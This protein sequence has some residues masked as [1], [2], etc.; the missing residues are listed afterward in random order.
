[1]SHKARRRPSWKKNRDGWTLVLLN[2]EDDS[3][4]D[5]IFFKKG[6]IWIK[7]LVRKYGRD[8]VQHALQEVL[9][10]HARDIVE[11]NRKC[12]ERA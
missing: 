3:H 6:N 4:L 2:E 9:I 10:G 8:A 11:S 12:V 7:R 1:M 5:S